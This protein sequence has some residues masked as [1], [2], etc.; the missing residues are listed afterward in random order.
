[1][2]FLQNLFFLLGASGLFFIS[3]DVIAGGKLLGSSG[4]TQVEGS[5]GA[6]IVPWATLSGS[7]TRDEMSGATFFTAISVDDFRMSAY[8]GSYAYHDRIE[9]SLAHQNFKSNDKA[10]QL[11]QNVMGMK[12]RLFGDLIYTAWPQVALGVQYKNANSP[13]VLRSLGA[14][15]DHGVDYYL[16]VTKAWL[17]GPLHR[18]VVVNTTLRYS[19]ANQIGLLGFGGDKQ[20]SYKGLFEASAAIFLTRHWLVGAEYRQKS[21][22]LK[23]IKEDDWK[24]VF[25][26]FVPNKHVALSFAVVDLGQ[27][28]G[29]NKQT[30]SYFSLQISY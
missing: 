20:D 17:D 22:Q 15:K 26:A 6:G 28:G 4:V 2:R 11:S 1:M 30:G 5:G 21:N 19:K 13:N 3:A 12:V 24:D 16:A 27:I 7:G 18:T 25:V 9:V 8:G 14:K 23:A 10:V 29:E